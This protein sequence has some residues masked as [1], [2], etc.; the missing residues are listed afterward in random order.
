MAV[1]WAAQS[2]VQWVALKVAQMAVQMAA[3]R[4]V[5]MVYPTADLTAD[6]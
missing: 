3:L 6:R 2:A 1:H 4:A 5:L